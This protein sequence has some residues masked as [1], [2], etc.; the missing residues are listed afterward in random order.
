MS[1]S[2]DGS[3]RCSITNMRCVQGGHAV[4]IGAPFWPQPIDFLL[5]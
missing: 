5:I 1:P 4:S 2:K 3:A